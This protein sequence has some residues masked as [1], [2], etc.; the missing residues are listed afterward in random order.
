MKFSVVSM[1]S[2]FAAM[3]AAVTPADITQP[4]TGNPIAAPGLNE[5]VPA[6]KPYT[7]S[8]EP[9]TLGQVSIL[10]L[11][12]P[13]DNVVPIATIADSVENTGS[14]VWTPS[15]ELEADVSHYGIQIIVEGTGQYQYSTQFGVENETPTEP[16]P[17]YPNQPPTEPEQ[18]E[19]PVPPP[20]V[21]LT[22]SIC[23][24]TVAPTGVAPPTGAP[25][26]TGGAYPT[27]TGVPPPVYPT[28]TPPPFEGAAG[29]NV[30][31]F[32]GAV[33]ALAAVLAF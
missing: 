12:G 17:E 29:R 32:G 25:Q 28:A 27:G 11:R 1:I 16:E 21:T 15:T 14:F 4:P 10:L 2:A 3:A 33:L 23:P 6:G 8:W 31:S 19:Y 9:T 5:L 18:P 22:T 26:P 7:I 13:S 30:A 20:V 24:P